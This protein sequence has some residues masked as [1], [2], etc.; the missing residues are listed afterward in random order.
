MPVAN[1]PTVLK[2]VPHVKVNELVPDVVIMNVTLC[3]AIP[4]D[5]LNVQAAEGVTV[6]AEV[7]MLTVIVPVVAEVAALPLFAP[8]A[9]GTM[10]VINVDGNGWYNALAV[11]LTM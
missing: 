2:F 3:P 8:L 5:A 1:V 10:P 6:I 11:L 4:P 9:K 7:D